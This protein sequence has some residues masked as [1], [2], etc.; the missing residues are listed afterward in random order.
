MLINNI[1]NGRKQD[2]IETHINTT[3][4]EKNDKTWALLAK[5]RLFDLHLLV[6]NS[7]FDVQVLKPYYKH[8][9]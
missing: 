5:Q 3:Q 2:L 6:T 7:I 1:S 8:P 9:C 4:M